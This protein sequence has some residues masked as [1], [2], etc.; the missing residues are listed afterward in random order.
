MKKIGL[1]GGTFDPIHNGHIMIAKE[2]YRQ[3]GLDEVWF[4]PVL[5]NPFEKNIIATNEQRI[6]MIK[7]ATAA[8]PYMKYTDIELKQDPE[9]K[10]Y[11]INTIKKLKHEFDHQFYFILGY[12]QA[13]M[14]DKWYK[15]KK[16]SKKV[17]LVVVARKGYQAIKNIENYSMIELSVEQI[18]VSSTA[19]K[20]GDITNIDRRV[21]KYTIDNSI[22]SKLFLE[23]H[24]SRKR[25]EHSIRVAKT[26]EEIAINNGINPV[27][28]Y[29]AGLFHDIAKEID[30]KLSRRIMNQ[31]FKK[32]SKSATPIIHQ[33]VS[34]FVCKEV[35]GIDDNEIL[36]AISKHTT[37]DVTMSLLDMCIYCADMYEPGRRYDTT[38]QLK[39][40]N[41]NIELAFKN[42]LLEF[43]EYSDET[44]VELDEIFFDVYNKYV[45]G[46]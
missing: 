16:I 18:D 11:S 14:F 5:N 17:Q 21:L 29:I 6:E 40:C 26:A 39:L 8:Y 33:W 45:K 35:Y 32:Y 37:G 12:D 30:E 1:I 20:K 24:L 19:I 22:Y 38:K 36:S 2:S 4:I 42:A 10:S 9:V 41:E 23:G 44:G 7:I 46:E 15:A 3:L 25:L 13:Q 34:A 27:K 31:Y 28:A 43:K